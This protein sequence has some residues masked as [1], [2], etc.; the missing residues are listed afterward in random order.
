MTRQKA[1]A[2]LAGAAAALMLATTASGQTAADKAAVDAAKAQGIV[3]EQADG[4]LG[5][6]KDTPDAALRASVAAINAG[7][8]QVYREAAQR[9]NVSPEAAGVAAFK[10]VILGRIPAGEYYKNSAGAWVRK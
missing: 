9:N 4:Y 2:T 3:G 7:R 8:A 6:V 1:L 10:E 5:F